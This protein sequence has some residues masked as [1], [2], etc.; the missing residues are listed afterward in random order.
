MLSLFFRWTRYR[1][2]VSNVVV[3]RINMQPWWVDLRIRLIDLIGC[4]SIENGVWS[5]QGSAKLGVHYTPWLPPIHRVLCS[6]TRPAF[7]LP[8]SDQI[9]WPIPMQLP[10]WCI[11]YCF[12]VTMSDL[13]LKPQV[14]V[15]L[16]SMIVRTAY[17]DHFFGY[18]AFFWVCRCTLRLVS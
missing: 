8:L 16:N 4:F 17:I 18:W 9:N 15:G 6:R 13:Y 2:R 1:V 11:R 5:S 14:L 10:V 3:I 7:F 12:S